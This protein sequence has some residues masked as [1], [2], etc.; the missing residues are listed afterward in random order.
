MESGADNRAEAV[1][2]GCFQEMD[3]PVE[4]IGIGESQ[5]FAAGFGRFLAEG[6]DGAHSLHHRVVGM[7]MEVNKRFRISD[8]GFR[9]WNVRGRLLGGVG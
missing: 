8:F 2:A 7:Y 9:M 3:Q 1:A 4:P 5:V 6:F